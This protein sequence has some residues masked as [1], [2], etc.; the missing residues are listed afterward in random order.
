[1][2]R[3]ITSADLKG[4]I[5]FYVDEISKGHRFRIIHDDAEIGQFCPVGSR[6]FVS[7]NEL[8]VLFQGIESIDT[9]SFISQ[10]RDLNF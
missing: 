4:N 2:P 8:I 6:Y 9:A 7:R 5:D 10:V 1:M 3:V